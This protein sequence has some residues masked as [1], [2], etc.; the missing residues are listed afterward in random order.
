[1]SPEDRPASRRE[2]NERGRRLAKSRGVE[3]QPGETIQ[4]CGSGWLVMDK[5]G[6]EPCPWAFQLADFIPV[7]ANDAVLDLGCGGGILLFAMAQV[8]PEMGFA[9]GVDRQ[10][11]AV[12]QAR[13]S[14]VLCGQ[15]HIK[16]AV[17][18][19]RTL[20]IARKFEI[21]VSNPPFY[22]RGWGR[23]SARKEI[24]E[25]THALHG[26]VNDFAMA[27]KSVLAPKGC[28]IMLYDGGR[29]RELLLALHGAGLEAK[30]VEFLEDDRGQFSRVIA[31]A[32]QQGNGL[33]VTRK[34]N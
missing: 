31:L 18:D 10:V 23:I 2:I 26:D 25:S 17:G 11:R 13:R 16:F 12:E 6:F 5:G 27:A 3:I 21:V 20:P 15:D 8:H 29:L 22:P 4:P 1:M 34:E 19:I 33:K 32:S 9:V 28:V 14:A 30:H 24:A 7:E